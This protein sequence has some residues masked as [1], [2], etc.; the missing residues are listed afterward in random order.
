MAVL[1]TLA[2]T[3]GMLRLSGSDYIDGAIILPVPLANAA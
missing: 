1:H 3:M 2:Q